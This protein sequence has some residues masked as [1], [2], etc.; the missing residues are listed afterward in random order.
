MFLIVDLVEEP[1]GSDPVSPRF[2]LVALQLADMRTEVRVFPQPR[3]YGPAQLADDLL[4]TG[5]G[6]RAQVPAILLG[7]EDP[8]FM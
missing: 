2:R 1:P 7:L 4:V 6:E 3:I 5:L 8:V